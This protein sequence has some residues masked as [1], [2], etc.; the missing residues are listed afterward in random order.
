MGS[1]RAFEERIAKKSRFEKKLYG[2]PGTRPPQVPELTYCMP[3]V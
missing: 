3:R 2:D 1:Y